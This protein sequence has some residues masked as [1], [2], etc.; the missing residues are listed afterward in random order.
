MTHEIRCTADHPRLPGR[1]CNMKLAAVTHESVVVV[2]AQQLVAVGPGCA[3]IDCA[4]CG[5]RYVLCPRPV[6]PERAVG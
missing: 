6:A 5:A 3:V 4:R 1:V 2:R